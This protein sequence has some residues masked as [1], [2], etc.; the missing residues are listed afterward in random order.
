MNF[1]SNF[2]IIYEYEK[3]CFHLMNKQFQ[4][5]RQRPKF[6]AL[7]TQPE[8]VGGGRSDLQLRDYQ[9]AGV[10]WLLHSWCKLV[11]GRGGGIC[12][13]RDVLLTEIAFKR[14]GSNVHM[15]G[16]GYGL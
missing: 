11:E 12:G 14:E 13:M 10:N 5:L 4:A 15:W 3:Y 8:Y 2:S 1:Y 16:K 9:L 6:S 7:K